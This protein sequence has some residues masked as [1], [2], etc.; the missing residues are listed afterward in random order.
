[1]NSQVKKIF[2][3]KWQKLGFDTTQKNLQKN[4]DPEIRI[5]KIRKEKSTKN[6]QRLN[7]TE[8]CICTVKPIP[9]MHPGF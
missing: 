1:M 4:L 9:K 3:S 6:C 2:F 5:T 7:N 8:M